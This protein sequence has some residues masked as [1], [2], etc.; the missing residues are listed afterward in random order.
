[1]KKLF[2]LVGVL[3][4]DG[5][6]KAQK[7]MSQFER[8][9]KKSLAPIERFGK[10]VAG[11]G[12]N[13]TKTFTV[14]IAL[15]GGS[16][17]KFGGDFEKAMT[18][19][20]SIMG[21]VSDGMRSQMEDVAMQLSE[22]LP[23]S[24][25]KAA[26]AYFYL[27]SAGKTAEQS[28]ALLPKVAEFATAGNFDLALATDLLTDAQS[29]LGLTSK[30]VAKDQ[31][32]LVRVS[33]VLV[34]ANTLANATVQQ[35]S[36]S[37]TNKAG[38]ALRILNK[39]VEEGVAVLAAYADQGIKADKAGEQLN[40]V[41]RDLQRSALANEEGFKRANIQ[42]YDNAGNMNNLGDIIGMLEN[43]FVGMS[44]KQRR[45]ELTML[46][47]QDRSIS[48]ML[49]LLGTSES[50]KTYEA[51]LRKAG[52][53]TKEVSDKQ[54]QSFN[55]Q[56]A[57]I[58]NR[59][60]NI[61]IE[62]SRSLLPV[63]KQQVIPV[64][65]NLTE[66]VKAV[67]E[68]FND[69]P[70][71]VQNTIFGFTAFIAV[72]GPALVVIG[73][74]IA[75]VKI[76]TT[77]VTGAKLAMVAFNAV[78]LAT[79]VGLIVA[80]LVGITAAFINLR[81]STDQFAN[82]FEKIKNSAQDQKAEFDVLSQRLIVLSERQNKSVQA[83]K[84]YTKAVEDMRSKYPGYFR[85]IDT[86]K[87]KHSELLEIIENQKKAFYEKLVMQMR[88][89]ELQVFVE[90]QIKLQKELNKV[91]ELEL[92]QAAEIQLR[93][94]RLE[95]LKEAANKSIQ[96][97]IAAR[98][99]LRDEYDNGAISLDD[100][101]K[102]IRA[103]IS[104]ISLQESVVYANQAAFQKLDKQKEDHHKTNQKIRELQK[105]INELMTK[106][107]QIREEYGNLMLGVNET[108][109]KGNKLSQD[110]LNL[111]EQTN[112]AT[113]E[114]IAATEKLQQEKESFIDNYQDRIE[115]LILTEK[116][117]LDLEEK[118]ALESAER[119]KLS[120]AEKE[121][122]QAYY[123]IRRFELQVEMDN[124]AIEA[125]RAKEEEI[126]R[127][128]K[129]AYDKKQL[130]MLQ[131][132]QAEKRKWAAIK[133]FAFSALSA[134]SDIY[135]LYT[136][137]QINKMDQKLA[138]EKEAIEASKL[139]EEEKQEKFAEID[140]T[141]AKKKKELQIKQAKASKA[142]AIFDATMGATQMA[143]NGFSTKPFL[144]LGLIM[145]GVATALGLAKVA[146]IAAQPL[147]QLA[148]G[149]LIKKSQGGTAVVVGEGGEDET[150]LPM[151]K[152]AFEIADR[153]MGRLSDFIFPTYNQPA[154]AMSGGGGS[155]AGSM[156]RP[157]EQH[158]HFG[159]VITT[160][161]GLKELERKLL[162]VRVGEQNRRGE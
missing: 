155:G 89:Q 40:I 75:S 139:G 50:I 19:S 41:L 54:M 1:M 136:N 96:K 23:A 132:E 98:Q 68:W 28:M 14:P 29:A 61:A 161:G 72:A 4:V 17:L 140:E 144:P 107:N 80:G 42:V 121:E 156:M 38:A 44:D 134:I 142:Q 79:P 114:Q 129:E 31:M 112:Q 49:T 12:M 147:P 105:E 7:S 141:Y 159:T 59:V 36:Q 92:T 83:Q 3:R 47:F 33:D 162:E 135:S 93:E 91:K 94:E 115:R 46:G 101:Q 151:R 69:L 71:G 104:D 137:N 20:L 26:E 70:E 108:K 100:F 154:L 5:L 131:E 6:E 90:R 63:I 21:D 52:G 64:L 57:T 18:N 148:D 152:G 43:R 39:D 56:M 24:S 130:L 127:I 82:Q 99:K 51:E 160:K 128:G 123:Y 106:E 66:R 110:E 53:T 67:A 60:V 48:A 76:I 97:E 11:V 87:T 117:Q 119:L 13:L 146:M 111:L 55:N 153:I 81:S 74:L 124:K 58:R 45:S 84:D 77:V 34:K 145:G 62:F 86:E 2:E 8:N 27:A 37:L 78:F 149:A 22:R 9:I 15:A 113:L 109:A 16:V 10:Q 138:K 120:E 73:K 103:S 150:V 35:F 118:R 122:I 85:D 25:E 32:N 88:E 125:E 143:I 157:V 30:D 158:I 116:E 126:A 95:P 65:E 102:G 133:G